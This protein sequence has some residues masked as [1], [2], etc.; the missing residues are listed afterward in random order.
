MASFRVAE[1]GRAEGNWGGRWCLVHGL[2]EGTGLKHGHSWLEF[3]CAGQRW[4]LDVTD[5]RRSVILAVKYRKL[6]RVE[7]AKEYTFREADRASEKAGTFGPWHH[8]GDPAPLK[9]RRKK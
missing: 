1:A 2:V 3:S 5:G 7:D 9:E 6:G 4:A 8:D